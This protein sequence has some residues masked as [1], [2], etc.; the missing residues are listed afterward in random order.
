[1]H[2]QG[3]RYLHDGS[4]NYLAMFIQIKPVLLHVF[5]NYVYFLQYLFPQNHL[6]DALR[7]NI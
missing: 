4:I 6:V 5:S 2:F 3:T 7:I 1:M